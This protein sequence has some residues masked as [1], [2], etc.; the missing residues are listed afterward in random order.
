MKKLILILIAIPVI[1]YSQKTEGTILFK[2]TV[3]M[4]FELPEEMQAYADKLPKEHSSNKELLFSSKESL[5]RKAESDYEAGME[6]YT[7]GGLK[8][9]MIMD[10]GQDGK[11]YRNLRSN[12]VIQQQKFLGKQFLIKGEDVTADWKVLGEQKKILGYA[13]IKAETKS[14]S[15][16]VTA[17]FCP[18]IPVSTGPMGFGGLPGMIMELSLNDGMLT[19]SAVKVSDEVGEIEEPTKGKEVSREEYEEI[20]K[21]RMGEMREGSGGHKGIMIDIKRSN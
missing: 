19:V 1:G 20:V 8:V 14:D 18:Q 6:D 15:S 4:D 21:E 5:Y 3:K 2:E 11:T 13:C 17:W 9:K 12:D 10:D 7:S 16:T